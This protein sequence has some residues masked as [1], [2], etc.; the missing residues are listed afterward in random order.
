M[1]PAPFQFSTSPPRNVRSITQDIEPL[2]Q[3]R[4][5]QFT[6][7]LLFGTEPFETEYYT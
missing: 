3:N 6:N 7:L 2:F 4:I 1:L 5:Y